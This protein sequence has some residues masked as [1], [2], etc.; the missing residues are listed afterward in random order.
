MIMP[1]KYVQEGDALIG[2]GAILLSRL[3]SEQTLSDLWDR[4]K[5]FTHIN[6][7]ERF[8]LTLDL[9]HILGLIEF[10]ENSIVRV[11]L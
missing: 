1:N 8:I 2:A 3:T 9:L 5:N 7:Y 4:T 10:K 11:S 6:N